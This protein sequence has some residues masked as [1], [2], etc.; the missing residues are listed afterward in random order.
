[1]KRRIK[2]SP[3]LATLVCSLLGD[4]FADTVSS[5][6]SKKCYLLQFDSVEVQFLLISDVWRALIT[7][8][9][10]SWSTALPLPRMLK[11]LPTL[12]RK[13]CYLNY[14]KGFVYP[15]LTLLGCNKT[16]YSKRDGI[17]VQSNQKEIFSMKKKQ[18]SVKLGICFHNCLLRQHIGH[19]YEI[20][21]QNTSRESSVVLKSPFQVFFDYIMGSRTQ[22]LYQNLEPNL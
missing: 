22:Q 2:S 8:S 17:R 1:M 20:S 11:P 6:E 14:H 4:D 19:M 7:L 16:C 12:K 15:Q 3:F 13:G 9:V 10:I 18:I 21:R 5:Q